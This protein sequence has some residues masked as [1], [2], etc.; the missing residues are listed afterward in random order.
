MKDYV[1][2]IL[3][4]YY[5]Q[6]IRALH[7]IRSYN[8]R[9]VKQGSNALINIPEFISAGD[10]NVLYRNFETKDWG[11]LIY[12]K[13]ILSS[14]VEDHKECITKESLKNACTQVERLA[15]LGIYHADIK[16]ENIRFTKNGE[17]TLIDFSHCLIFNPQNKNE[18]EKYHSKM[19]DFLACS[20][21]KM[22]F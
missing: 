9:Q 5:K 18:Y 8:R 14:Y 10:I 22:G 21:E 11:F 15:Q 1:R 16:R 4:E 13:F 20:F 3:R 19:V 6:E 7:K 17:V 12:G 2:R